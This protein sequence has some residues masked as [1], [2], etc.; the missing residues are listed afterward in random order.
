LN[1]MLSVRVQNSVRASLMPCCTIQ[2]IPLSDA[3]GGIAVCAAPE[4][5]GRHSHVAFSSGPKLLAGYNQQWGLDT[6][7]H[8]GVPP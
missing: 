1:G 4:E 6:T 8:K 2:A 7:L 3:Y 5:A